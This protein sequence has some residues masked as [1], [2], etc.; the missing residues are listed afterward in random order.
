MSRCTFFSGSAPLAR[1]TRPG[2]PEEAE[3]Q[4]F[5]PARAGNTSCTS[6]CCGGWAVQPRSRG[7]HPSLGARFR[8]YHGSAPLARGTPMSSKRNWSSSR[9][10]PARAGNTR[11]RHRN[12]ARLTVQPR[13]RG[14]H[15][16]R[17]RL[18][19]ARHGSAPLA[20]GTPRP[21]WSNPSPPRF[22]P[23]RA[24]N[25]FPCSVAGWILPVQ[26]RSRGEHASR[27]WALPLFAGSAPLARGT[28]GGND[29]VRTIEL[30]RSAPLARGTRHAQP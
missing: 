15:R 26:P 24:G 7:E 30:V 17:A 16:L 10:S 11:R 2:S 21:L 14:E 20:R 9:F 3:Q 5:S 6:T 27:V 4:R 29:R 18:T 13:S 22:S 12:P 1:G 19:G 23:A 25:T 28:P 8:Q